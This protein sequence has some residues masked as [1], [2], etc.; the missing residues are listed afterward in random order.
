M[1]AGVSAAPECAQEQILVLGALGTGMAYILN[2]GLIREAGATAASTVGYLVPLFATVAGVLVLG[3][4]LA[5]YEPVGA[6]IV[7]L[8]VAISQGRIPLA[9]RTVP[10]EYTAI[11]R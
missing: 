6:V 9:W 11:S 2:Y 3:E 4:P 7:I 8:G 1:N 10:D 5:W